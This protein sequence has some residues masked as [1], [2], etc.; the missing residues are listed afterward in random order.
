MGSGVHTVPESDCANGTPSSSPTA[1]H[2]VTDMHDNPQSNVQFP[3][4]DRAGTT[5]C[6]FDPDKLSANGAVVS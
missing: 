4:L 2:D 5:G 3:P 1:V 6:H